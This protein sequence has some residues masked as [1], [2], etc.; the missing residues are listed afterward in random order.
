MAK[1]KVREGETGNRSR[2]RPGPPG[3]GREAG[4]GRREPVERLAWAMLAQ[5][6]C[7]WAQ[8]WTETH[9]IGYGL[10]EAQVQA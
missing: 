2:G 1:D 4:L 9:S 8:G 6:R 10:K 5:A 7:V 3:T